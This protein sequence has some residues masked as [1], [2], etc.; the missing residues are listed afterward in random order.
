MALNTSLLMELK[1]EAGNTRKMLER[2]PYDNPTWKPHDKSSTLASLA[3]H[4]A[5][6]PVWVERIITK[7]EFDVTAP[8]AFPKVETP[9]TSKELLD[10]FDTNIAVVS[11]YLEQASDET[12]MKPWTFRMGDKVF[13]TLP[14]IAAIRDMAFS[15]SYH[16]RG[17][18]SVY[19]RLLNVPIPGMYGPSADEPR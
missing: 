2:V 13:F 16:H 19:L 8:N 9:K 10:I 3:A 12:L 18:L 1:H 14:R 5:R 15:H 7:D 4:I 17:Q 6:L 11:K